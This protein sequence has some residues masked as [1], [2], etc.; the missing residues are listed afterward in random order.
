MIAVLKRELKAYFTSVIGWIFLAAFF[1]VYNLYF[2]ANNLIY[3]TPYLSYSLNNVAFVLL[4]IIPILAMRSMSDDR[5]TKTDQLLYTSPVSIPKVILGK[6]FALVIVFSIVVGAICL[7]P[8]LLARFGSVPI[9]ESYAAILGLWL[10]GC[11]SISICVFVSSLTESQV[12]AAVLSFA[13]LFIGY[14]MEGITSIISSSGNTLTKI[15]NCLSTSTALSNFSNGML[16]V[17]GIIYYVSG[18]VLFLFLTCQVVQKHRWTVSSK[19]IRRGVFNSSFVVIGIA[20][21]VAVNV[22]ANQLPEKVKNVDLTT[23]NLYTLTEDSVNLV[24]N[25]K[26][27]VTLY[28]LSN[29]KS[30]DD[31]VVR[32]LENYADES[33]HIKV[34]YVD[35]AVSPNFYASYTDTAPSDGSIIVVSGDTSKVVDANDLYEY[36]V[37]Y[38]TY[39]QTK[40][41]YDGEGQLTSAIS[42]VTSEDMPKVYVITGHGETTLD[43]SFKSALEKMN[44]SVEEITLLQEKAIP[45]DAAGIII[46]GPTSDFSADDAAKVSDYLAGGG[47]AVITTSYSKT[48]ETPNFDGILAAYD[49]SV[50]EGLVMDSD[51]SHYYQYPFYLLPDVASTD[52]TSKVDNYVFMAYAQA[53]SNTGEHPDTITWTDLLTTSENAYVKT[54]IANIK[55]FEKESGDQ[56]GSFSVAANVTDSETGANITIVGSSLAFTSDADSMVS[57]QNLA[58]F[59][60]ITSSFAGTDSAVSIDAKQYTYSTL[61]VNQSVAIMSETLLV[62]VLPVALI[63]VGIVIW[64]RR[65]RA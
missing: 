62:M 40:S 58:L 26:Q 22:F 55:T 28:V 35:P 16:D 39:T 48:A 56:T 25:L 49:I 45:E 30:A 51:Q 50:T 31:T 57:G 36:S 20:I 17:T 64:Y 23:Q 4:I 10:Y 6:F 3:G 65:R 18:T 37:D 47:K 61:S 27:D 5:R 12:I 46:N 44:I 9:A 21:A 33:S 2:V 29:E 19:K 24:K 13:L 59:K 54:D 63:V 1:F 14:M 32:S 8:P 42:Y 11:L 60:G 7:C 41:A 15:L 43:D 53:I 38:S 34:E 52:Q